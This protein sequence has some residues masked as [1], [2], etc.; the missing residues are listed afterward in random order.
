MIIE[1]MKV[2]IIEILNKER[3]RERER[4][5]DSKMRRVNNNDGRSFNNINRAGVIKEQ[6]YE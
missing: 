6:N 5:H 4:E 3:E 1:K 2:K